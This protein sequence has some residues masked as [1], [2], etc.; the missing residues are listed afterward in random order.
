MLVLKQPAIGELKEKRSL[1]VA[2]LFPVHSPEEARQQIQ[3]VQQLCR[4]ANHNCWAY[5]LGTEGKDVFSSDQGEPAGTAG[6]PMLGV[7]QK[8]NLTWTVAVVSRWFGGIKL[9]VRGLID[10]YSLTVE[11]ALL[12]ADMEELIPK[13]LALVELPYPALTRFK[14]ALPRWQIIEQKAEYDTLARLELLLPQE[15]YPD[16]ATTAAELGGSCTIINQF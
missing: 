15:F 1:F 5:V 14:H 7:L 4:D 13:T 11:N 12:N 16:L 10:A 3:Q 9:G 6:R 2:R 8:H